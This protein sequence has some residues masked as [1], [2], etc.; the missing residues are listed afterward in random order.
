MEQIDYGCRAGGVLAG[1]RSGALCTR[2]TAHRNTTSFHHLR[3]P[4]RG[5]LQTEHD[6]AVV[7]LLLI[8][9][10]ALRLNQRRDEQ[11]N[12]DN[13]RVALPLVLYIY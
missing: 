5:S 3:C 6:R 7:P 10:D 2:G 13:C 9:R 8:T 1:T 11:S 4:A 12:Y